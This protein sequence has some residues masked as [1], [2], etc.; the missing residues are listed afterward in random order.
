[1]TQPGVSK[2]VQRLEAALGVTLLV[3]RDTGVEMTETGRQVYHSAKEILQTW[4]GL[5]ESC[6][7]MTPWMGTTLKIGASSIP[8][9]YL[10]PTPMAEFLRLARGVQISVYVGD[11]RDVLERLVSR[12]LDVACVGTTPNPREVDIRVMGEDKLVLITHE[13]WT[14]EFS[15]RESPLILRED[16]SGTRLA[17]EKELEAMGVS[18]ATVRRAAEVNDT[19]LILRMVEKGMGTAVVS[20]LHAEEALQEGRRIRILREFPAGRKFYLAWLPQSE[21]MSVIRKFAESVCR[22]LV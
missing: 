17:M 8:A 3:R 19:D 13:D 7:A 2:Q 15:W 20:S 4:Q 11:S 18:I 12:E 16:G 21:Q 5:V 14:D 22:I 9:K 10:L 6:R 1:M